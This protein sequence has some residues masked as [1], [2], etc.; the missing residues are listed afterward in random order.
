MHGSLLYFFLGSLPKGKKAP[1]VNIQN[2]TLTAG[3]GETRFTCWMSGTALKY[4]GEWSVFYAS[5]LD[6]QNKLL[7]LRLLGNN[8]KRRKPR[9][10]TCTT[11]LARRRSLRE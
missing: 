4:A 7:P 3:S 11:P 10:R 6:C 9:K 8:E 1:F 5:Q 2:G